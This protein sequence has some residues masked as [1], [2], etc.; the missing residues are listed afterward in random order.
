MAGA[1][2]EAGEERRGQSSQ[3]SGLSAGE[4]REGGAG[5]PTRLRLTAP[6]RCADAPALV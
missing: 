5:Q 1:G 3:A 2:G 4:P 6:P